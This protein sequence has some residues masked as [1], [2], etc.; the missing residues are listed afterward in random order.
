M[1]KA[2]YLLKYRRTETRVT[3]QTKEI[4]RYSLHLAFCE[5]SVDFKPHGIVSR[6]V[7]L[8][9]AEMSPLQ[10]IERGF[11]YCTGYVAPMVN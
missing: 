3:A 5:T 1:D 4:L 8:L 9:N 6:K 10:F 2:H 11:L 7:E